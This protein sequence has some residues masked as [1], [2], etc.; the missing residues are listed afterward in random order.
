MS[1]ELSKEQQQAFDLYVAGE[2]VFITG[3]AGSGKSRIIRH[4]CDHARNRGVQVSVCA[5]TGRAAVLL[6]CRASTFHSWAGIGL[7]KGTADEI[8]KKLSRKGRKKWKT[9]ELL[10]VDEVSMMSHHLFNL[11]DTIARTLRYNI[12]FGGM[13]VIFSGD[14]FQLPPIPDYKNPESGE[15]CFESKQ[16][17]E[18]FPISNQLHFQHNFRQTD[19]EFVAMLNRIRKGEWTDDDIRILHS[20]TEKEIEEGEFLPTFMTPTRHEAETMNFRELENIKSTKYTF[21]Q[22]ILLP[23]VL[24]KGVSMA[25]AKKEADKLR[26]ALPIESHLILKQGA[27]VMCTANLDVEVGICNGSQG[28]ITHFRGKYPVVKFLNG[29]VMTVKPNTWKSEEIEGVG[30][31]QLPLLL[32]WALTIHRSQGSTLE[33]VEVNGGDDIFADGQ[34]YVALSRVKS[35]EKLFLTDFD[36]TSLRVDPKVVDYYK[37]LH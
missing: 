31:R 1:L 27:N 30:I 11:C 3:V 34:L 4:I 37:R 15:Y 6:E 7:G 29:V 5:M 23:Q 9:T 10:I 32:S 33:S 14:F 18:V 22:E 8:L 25:Q 21:D 19:M 24:P 16:W 28:V 36:E 2:N 13:Q 35:M 26:A 20:L 12:P 17:N